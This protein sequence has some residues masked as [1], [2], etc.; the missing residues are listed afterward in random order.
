VI[1]GT[2]VAV[3]LQNSTAHLQRDPL[4]IASPLE[5]SRSSGRR[6][7]LPD[8]GRRLRRLCG[9]LRQAR[10][11]PPFHRDQP[12]NAGDVK[13]RRLRH[14]RHRRAARDGWTGALGAALAGLAG[15]VIAPLFDL[16]PNM[17]TEVVFKG[18]A[19]VIIGGMGTSP[20]QRSPV[21]RSASP[22]ELRRQA[23]SA[24]LREVSPS[25]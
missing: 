15:V 11:L 1:I 4:D 19:V 7:P 24:V 6:A 18:F 9:R 8:S 23:G 14:G 20:A 22:R 10:R 13:P 3:I 17:G 21:S 12:G 25:R 5:A 16:Y 2:L